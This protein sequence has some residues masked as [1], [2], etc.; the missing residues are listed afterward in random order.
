[1]LKRGGGFHIYAYYGIANENDFIMI[2]KYGLAF[3]D[4]KFEQGR[5]IAI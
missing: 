5:I 1:M 4:S 3:V 2:R